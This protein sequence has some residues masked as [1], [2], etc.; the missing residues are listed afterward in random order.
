MTFANMIHPVPL[1][2]LER[3][4]ELVPQAVIRRPIGFARALGFEPVEGEDD[5]DRYQGLALELDGLAFALK[6]YAGHPDG[7]TTLYLPRTVHD[8]E[9]ISG[10]V[11]A[12]LEA[13]RV[14]R[15]D[16]DWQRADGPDF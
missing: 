14:P 12:V 11:A 15:T 1:D 9:E 4:V 3:E 13:L 6:H 5:F 2:V 7:T 8:L 10:C 16:I